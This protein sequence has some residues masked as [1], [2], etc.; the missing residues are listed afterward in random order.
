MK[1]KD[2]TNNIRELYWTIHSDEV[3]DKSARYTL[4]DR[5]V[6][7][8]YFLD[9]IR[10]QQKLGA[11]LSV[12]ND[13][14]SKI[15]NQ[16]GSDKRTYTALVSAWTGIDIRAPE[17]LPEHVQQASDQ[18]IAWAKEQDLEKALREHA[19]LPTDAPGI[20]PIW[21]LSALVLCGELEKL[22]YYQASF[23][24]GD[25][26]GFVPYITK[27]YIDR[28]VAAAVALP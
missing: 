28:A 16:V 11:M 6:R 25:R 2:L 20:Q 3:G 26:L 21:H 22:R 14:F 10:D 1:T 27:D 23:E 15:C 24:A 13:Q 19:A 8:I 17:I 4:P 18:A 7:I 5:I 9:I 12:S